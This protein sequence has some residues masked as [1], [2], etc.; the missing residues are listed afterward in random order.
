M[1]AIKKEQAKIRVCTTTLKN[2]LRPELQNIEDVNKIVDIISESQD[3]VTDV[4]DELSL[5]LHKHLLELAQGNMYPEELEPLPQQTFDLTRLF[6]PGF[7]FRYD[8]NP[9][10]PTSPLP[11]R[12]QEHLVSTPD[13]EISRIFSHHHL[14]FMYSSLMGP[15]RSSSL[16]N[17]PLWKR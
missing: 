11:R 9:I 15:N 3:K 8:V 17:Y 5:L 10:V 6:P 2:I 16:D 7:K 4:I 12:L 1:D 14:Q 13:G